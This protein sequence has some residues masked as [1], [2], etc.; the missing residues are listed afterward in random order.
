MGV[1]RR[2]GGGG[3]VARRW[4][5]GDWDMVGEGDGVGIVGRLW[6]DCGGMEVGFWGGGLLFMVWGY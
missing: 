4:W 2:W 5:G 1:A 3:V 6:G